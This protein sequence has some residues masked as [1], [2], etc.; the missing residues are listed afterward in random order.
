MAVITMLLLAPRLKLEQEGFW[1]A[2]RERYP[3][4]N[5]HKCLLLT[6]HSHT[7]SDRLIPVRRAVESSYGEKNPYPSASWG[8]T[9]VT[10]SEDVMVQRANPKFSHLPH[11]C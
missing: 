8:Q 4:D 11:L 3:R 6:L 1:A 5:I 2:S 9:S 10:A 7:D